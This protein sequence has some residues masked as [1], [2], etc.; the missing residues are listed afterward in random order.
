MPPNFMRLNQLLM[1]Q[2]VRFEVGVEEYI[3]FILHPFEFIKKSHAY[4]VF[5]IVTL[6]VILS[7]FIDLQLLNNGITEKHNTIGS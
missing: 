7:Y 4:V 5:I 2:K 1:L 3:F 6:K